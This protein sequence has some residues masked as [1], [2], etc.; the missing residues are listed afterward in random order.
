MPS[1]Q[2]FKIWVTLEILRLNNFQ[3]LWS[4]SASSIPCCHD[5]IGERRKHKA[6][7]VC[8]TLAAQ[9]VPKHLIL[10]ICEY[11]SVSCTHGSEKTRV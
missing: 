10:N 9:N 11:T 4:Q 2:L 8:Y 5:K 1:P 7:T 6:S 3:P